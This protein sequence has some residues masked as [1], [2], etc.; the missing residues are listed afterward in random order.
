MSDTHERP[1]RSLV[2]APQWVGDAIM[3]EPLVRALSLRG[4]EVTVAA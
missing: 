3:S 1:R 4:D 2:I